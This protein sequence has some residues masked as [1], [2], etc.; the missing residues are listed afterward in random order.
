[1]V[2]IGRGA[3][4]KVF[5]VRQFDDYGLLREPEEEL[6]AISRPAAIQLMRPL[7]SLHLEMTVDP[8]DHC[9]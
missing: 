4:N 3:V 7:A 9:F 8:F 5:V 6:S 2:V 1:M